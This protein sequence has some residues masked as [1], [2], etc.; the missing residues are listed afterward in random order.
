VQVLLGGHDLAVAEEFHDG[1]QVRATGE[2]PRQGLRCVLAQADVVQAS[3]VAQGY[4]SGL[5]DFVGADPPVPIAADGGCFRA[6]GV[7][8]GRRM[9]GWPFFCSS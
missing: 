4:A 8:L 2:Q 5:V 7:D 6:C 9:A 3:A 1:G